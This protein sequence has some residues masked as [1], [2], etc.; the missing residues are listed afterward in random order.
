MIVLTERVTVTTPPPPLCD[1]KV[2]LMVMG[3]TRLGRDKVLT[4]RGAT[5]TCSAPQTR[6]C[7]EPRRRR[8]QVNTRQILAT[9]YWMIAGMGFTDG[10]G[11][12][13][14]MGI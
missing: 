8:R 11:R 7:A 10:E 4:Q 13:G 2:M 6:V 1:E 14:G 5:K 3:R 9:N 12:E